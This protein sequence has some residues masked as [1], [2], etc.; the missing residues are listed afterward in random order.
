[1]RQELVDAGHDVNIVSIHAA[2]A[3]ANQGALIDECAFP[4]LQDTAE[5]DAWGQLGGQKDDFFVLDAA[6]DVVAH[7]VLAEV[8]TNLST[9]DGYAN[10]RGALLAAEPTP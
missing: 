9:D 1:M 7:L 5:V 2:S 10:V 3:A 8:N 4:L 6:G